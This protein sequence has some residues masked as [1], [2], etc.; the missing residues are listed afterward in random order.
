MSAESIS[1]LT[2]TLVDVAMGR[3]SA[4][5]VIRNGR[6]VSVQSGEIIPAT[7]IAIKKDRIAFVGP[8]ASH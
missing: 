6:W 3:S 5:L 7:D 4:D 2:R 8:D 1:K